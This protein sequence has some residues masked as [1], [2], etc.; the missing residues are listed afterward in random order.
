MYFQLYVYA[1]KLI[2]KLNTATPYY[3][4]EVGTSQE[5]KVASLQ[6][7]NYFDAKLFDKFKGVSGI[8]PFTIISIF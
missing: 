1:P 3:T 6:S 7:I 5:Q 2:W 8:H 4:Y